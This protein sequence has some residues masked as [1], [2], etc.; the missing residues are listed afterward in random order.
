MA[1]ILHNRINSF[2][3]LKLLKTE[4]EILNKKLYDL[5]IDSNEKLNYS[6]YEEKILEV[7]P[8]YIQIA[9]PTNQISLIQ[10]FEMQGYRYV[11]MR[12]QK[13]LSLK[14]N[15]IKIDKATKFILETVNTDNEL[16][17][18]IKIVSNSEFEDR[19]SIDPLFPSMLAKQRILYFI[20]KSF[21]SDTE[22]LLK[23]SN[24]KTK[25]IAG[26]QSC[27]ISSDKEAT[28]FL[29]KMHSEFKDYQSILDQSVVNYL[30]NIG[31]TKIHEVT[32]AVNIDEINRRTGIQ[33]FVI[34]SS[35]ILLRKNFENNY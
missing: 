16:N 32:S 30:I 34:N 3:Y 22:L 31:I 23:F 13:T 15:I 1:D 9:I 12:L 28:L 27:S 10:Y 33:G 8:D 24:K 17:D 6:L 19:F 18:I 2:M 4:S 26:F 14:K 20:K 5:V 21:S 11:E 7:K 35:F 29:T 25:I